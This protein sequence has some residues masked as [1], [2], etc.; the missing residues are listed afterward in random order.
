MPTQN[1]LSFVI[2]V[3]QEPQHAQ[4]VTLDFKIRYFRNGQLRGLVH[5]RLGTIWT[6]HQIYVCFVPLHVRLVLTQQIVLHVLL[7]MNL[8]IINNVQKN[9]QMQVNGWQWMS[10]MIWPNKNYK[11]VW[12][13]DFTL[14]IMSHQCWYQIQFKI[15]QNSV[16]NYSSECIH[17][18]TI[19]K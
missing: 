5:V 12:Q 10:V 7:D 16:H 4:L 3:L 1:V 2:R 18:I 19:P 13:Q 9:T 15:V 8:I 11:K 6:R 14:S 17:S